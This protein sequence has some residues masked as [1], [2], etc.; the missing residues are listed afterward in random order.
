MD[1]VYIWTGWALLAIGTLGCFVPVLPGPP[2]AFASF[3]MAYAMG[4]IG[5]ITLFTAA[6]VT[7]AVTALDYVVP[8]MGARKFNCSKAGVVGCF[9]G[10]MIGL[11]FLPFGMIIGAFVGALL[12]EAVVAGK[13]LE[14]ALRGAFGAL[15]GYLAGMLLK[16][17]CCGFLAYWFYKAVYR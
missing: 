13:N 9:A 4:A 5:L 14:S 16:L 11:F 7:L 8:A 6:V 10:T 12:G 1:T 17:S 3:F 2:V 15:L